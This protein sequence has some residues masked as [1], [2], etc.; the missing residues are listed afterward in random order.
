PRTLVPLLGGLGLLALFVVHE[1]R[2]SSP[3]LDLRVLRDPAFSA[4]LALIF[5]IAVSLF[6]SVFLLPLFLQQVQGYG[7]L[8]AGLIL[9][10]QAVAAGLVMPAGGVLTDRYGAQRVVP[11][12]LA[13][14]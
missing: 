13:L 8:H 11:I 14:L 3:L 7:P 5:L 12:G 6:S 10:T 9:S 4:S 1:L 2:T